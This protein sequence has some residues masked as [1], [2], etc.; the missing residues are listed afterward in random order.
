MKNYICKLPPVLFFFLFLFNLISLLFNPAAFADQAA[1]ATIPPHSTNFQFSLSTPNGSAIQHDT[2]QLYKITY[3]AYKS[4]GLS[5]AETITA[6]WSDAL[7]PEGGQLF[8]YIDGSASNAYSG[9]QP[10]IDLINHTITWMI[11]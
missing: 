4:A 8:T 9:A 5:T 1:S 6:D 11:P 2:Q 10:V 7:D 3:G